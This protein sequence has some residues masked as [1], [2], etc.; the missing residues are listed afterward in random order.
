MRAPKGFL[1]SAAAAGIKYRERPDLGL[2]LS[3]APATW[4]G[5]FTRNDF[6]AAP[7]LLGLK[8]REEVPRVRAILV[9]SGCANACTGPE[10]LR[11]AETLLEDLAGRLG[12]PPQEIL[13]ASTGVIGTRL[14]VERIREAFPALVAGLSPEKAHLVARAMMTTDTFPKVVSRSFEVGGRS[15]TLLGMAKG[16]GMIAPHLATMLAFL[17]TD[18]G[19]PSAVLTPTLREAVEASFNRI[20]VDGDTSTNDTVYLLANGQAGELPSGSWDSFREVLSGV[21]REL[22]ALIVRDAEGASKLVKIVV[23]G[24]RSSEEAERLARAVA[25]SPLVKTAFFGEDPNWGRILVAMGKLGLGL[26]P[27]RVSIKLNGVPLVEGGCGLP[28]EPARKEMA[29]PEFTLE[30]Q[31]GLGEASFEILTCDLSYDYV[32]INAE[33]RT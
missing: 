23:R 28:E 8:R 17:L 13:P 1:F 33:Y 11:D 7:V 30:I 22:A 12:I 21:C 9:N 16:A 26:I 25:D 29:R 2:I 31:L 32:K 6:K 18:A 5:V 20:T 4:A 14:P 24:A 27:E 15:F 19:L 10:G 3:E